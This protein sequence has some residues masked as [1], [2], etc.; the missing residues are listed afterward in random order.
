[1]LH[2]AY[3]P[4]HAADSHNDAWHS[5]AVGMLSGVGF[6]IWSWVQHGFANIAYLKLTLFFL[7]TVSVTE[8]L[9]MSLF[10]AYLLKRA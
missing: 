10:H 1:M 7:Y 8:S 9:A 4:K 5:G 6:V 3:H 2:K